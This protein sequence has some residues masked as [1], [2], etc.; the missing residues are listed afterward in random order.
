[1]NNY[2]MLSLL[3]KF[4]KMRSSLIF[5]LIMTL[6]F[7]A[8][9]QMTIDGETLYGNEWIDYDKTYY[10]FKIA[11]DG[12]HR[13]TYDQL[14]EMGFPVSET[15]GLNIKLYRHGQQV[16]LYV[17]TNAALGSSDYIEFMAL[18]NRGEID[19]HLYI[20]GKADQLNPDYSLFSDSTSYY[21]V[22][23]NFSAGLRFSETSTSGSAT[24]NYYLHNEEQVFTNFHNKPTYRGGDQ[25]QYSHFDV[26][27]GWGSTLGI[28]TIVD[29]STE[30]VINTAQF[31]PRLSVRYGA[32][33]ANHD[34][35]ID[36]NG[37]IKHTDN[38]FGFANKEETIDLT[39][40]ELENVN[41]IT[42][43][44]THSN[45]DRHTMAY[46]KLLYPRETKFSGES[47][48]FIVASSPFDRVFEFEVENGNYV[49]VDLENNNRTE[50]SS[51]NGTINFTVEPGTE[52]RK[53]QIYRSDVFTLAPQAS[54]KNFIDYTQEDPSYLI[55][56]SKKLCDPTDPSNAVVRY[57]DYRATGPG[58]EHD[59]FTVFAQ[60]L[61]EQFA[62]GIDRHNIA[63]RNF[64]F[65]VQ[66][67]WPNLEFWFNLGKGIEYG[68]I[69]KAS[70]DS[71][72][73]QDKYHV[74]TYGQP[75]SDILMMS[76]VDKAV[77]LYAVGRFAGATE[78]E[79][80]DYLDKVIT[81]EDRDSREQ[82]Y[83][84]L[85]WQ[86]RV[87]HLSGGRPEDQQIIFNALENMRE[88]IEVNEFGA[89]VTTLRKFSADNDDTSLAD[90]ASEL[91]NGG[92]SVVTFFGHSAPGVFD[93]SLEDPSQY[94]N[95]GKYPFIVSLGCYSGNIHT[96]TFGISEDFVIEPEK[97]AIGF[98][99]ASGTAYIFAQS[100]TGRDMYD[101]IG[102]ALY[103]NSLGNVMKSLSE[104]HENNQTLEYRTLMQ[105]F[106][107]H[108]DPALVINSHP[109]VDL[110]FC[111]AEIS[112]FPEVVN[113][114]EKEFMLNFTV[115]NIGSYQPDSVDVKVLHFD[116]N[117]ELLQ[118]KVVRIE[119]PT[120][121]IEVSM[122]LDVPDIGAI[123]KNSIEIIIDP[124][125]ELI[126]VPDPDAE[127]NNSLKVLTDDVGFCFF[128]LDNSAI[129]VSPTEFAIINDD[130]PFELL[131]STHN[132]F[133]AETLFRFEI[134]TTE[135]FNSPL[136]EEGQ[137]LSSGGLVGWTPTIEKIENTVYFWRVR[138]DDSNS[139]LGINW[140]NSSFVYQSQ[141]ALG[142]N[143]S[144]YYQYLKDDLQTL[145]IDEDRE[146]VYGNEIKDIRFD[147][148]LDA[149]LQQWIFIDGSPWSSLNQTTYG[150]FVGSFTFD[151]NEVIYFNNADHPYSQFPSAGDNFI[152]HLDTPESRKL[153]M[154]LMDNVPVGSRTFIS[155]QVVNADF[156]WHIED[157]E[158]D[159]EIYGY[160][161][162][163]KFK[164]NGIDNIDV[165]SSLG[166]VPFLIA[167]EKGGA[168]IAQEFGMDKNAVIERSYKAFWKFKDGVAESTVIGPVAAWDKI[169][170]D[171]SEL[172]DH[173]EINI[174]V[175]GIYPDDTEEL[176]IDRNPN[177]LIDLGPL[178]ESNFRRCRLVI[179]SSDSWGPGILES[180]RTSPQIEFMRVLY[181][182]LPDLALITNDAEFSYQADTLAQGQ[183]FKVSLPIRN[184]T[185]EDMGPTD[186]TLRIRDAQNVEYIDTVAVAAIPAKSTAV[187]SIERGTAQFSGN[188]L[189]N[190]QLN[191][192]ENPEEQYYFNNFGLGGF[193]IDRDEINPILEVTFDGVK[194]NNGDVVSASPVIIINSSDENEYLPLDDPSLFKI[195]LEK[196]DGNT[197]S[198]TISD[199]EIS[200][201]P[202]SGPE[203]RASIT[204]TPQNLADGV[205][206]LVVQSEDVSGNVS[207]SNEYNV[208]FEVINKKAI[209]NV[210]NYPN[211]FSTSTQFIFNV[212]GDVAPE[213]VLINI[214][215]LSGKLVK[216]ILPEELG[217]V[218]V[219]LNRSEYKWNGT[220]D[221]GQKLAAGTYLYKA[222][223]DKSK[224]DKLETSGDDLFDRGFGKMV[225]L[226]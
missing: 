117:G 70:N 29:L 10:K 109:G 125:N 163:D 171:A 213:G 134:D 38:F 16:P 183:P 114:A 126:E 4:N 201:T 112:T 53:I 158:A 210:Y 177:Q 143:Q 57:A 199:S 187:V 145:K 224:Y 147:L 151:P 41:T 88:V 101:F 166:N 54:E 220:D 160:N 123:G 23:D 113:P 108:A 56:T 153:L 40:G 52:E 179:N 90:S 226:R 33:S 164:E 80:S 78:Q 13:I 2:N 11:D 169:E 120:D 161:L 139:A 137:V 162:F 159:T 121:K 66:D 17:S 48:E 36:V 178:N 219:G 172:E 202:A 69:R 42:L 55:L 50:V 115:A 89:E 15:T 65:F 83:E 1:M 132:A 8:N 99:A 82:T 209:S 124:E 131:A 86:K 152:Y 106:T 81:Y 32:N 194:I 195:K 127:N 203:N 146:W 71:Q 77:P 207:G 105:Q 157:W 94:T 12:A 74:P 27:E 144:H 85:F 128:V 45:A 24:Q 60:D 217:P 25:I 141:G 190:L 140:N 62:Y 118:E 136:L 61:I 129:P 133:I 191:R 87:L 119:V 20:N 175:Y 84:D 51:S 138:T 200:F 116:P 75:G 150:N 63:S 35:E 168:A 44:G 184:Y 148:G 67:K 155:T 5:S 122:S 208:N 9:A 206:T 130:C 156:D 212:T 26:S 100:I 174:S 46:A 196:P 97:A 28:E 31:V 197:Q 186:L 49:V 39:I 223:Y 98:L 22:F 225:I 189:W 7:F 96:P 216:Q 198:L 135:L 14:V 72:T 103:R 110:T 73:I 91:I 3:L 102:E 58:G 34:I 188:Y 185:A 104:T 68:T 6:G 176:L 59:V 30:D 18:K 222:I 173:D 37:D 149:G 47:L 193:T 111:Q 43:R 181:R 107:L 182:Q 92:L 165:L 21:M 204:Y 211:P 79:I 154:D 192:K 215:T 180:N 19:E 76:A 64:A 142:W 93:L 205:Y 167:F 214:Y 221:F 218:R 95:F 170:W